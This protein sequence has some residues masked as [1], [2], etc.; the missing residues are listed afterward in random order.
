MQSI[1][2]ILSLVGALFFC[3]LFASAQLAMS[4]SPVM[5]TG[6][7]AV[8][9]LT[10][11]NGFAEKVES[12]GAVCF[13]LDDQGKI[14]G[15]ASRWIIGGTGDKVGLAAGA[16]N[17]FNFVVTATKPFIATNLTAK[18]T[19]SRVVMEGGKLADVAK[20]VTFKSADK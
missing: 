5:T 6:Q 19:F 12:A 7:K 10:I 4:V 17:V 16:T 3:P 2:K 18:V 11:K 20:Q 1:I 15:Q 9:P 13:L 14:V 8:V